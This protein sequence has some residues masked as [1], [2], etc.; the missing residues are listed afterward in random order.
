MAAHLWKRFKDPRPHESIFLCCA[1]E[2]GG[3]CGAT[4]VFGPELL[5]RNYGASFSPWQRHKQ[6]AELPPISALSF[7]FQRT[8]EGLAQVGAPMRHSSVDFLVEDSMRKSGHKSWRNQLPP[9]S[10]LR[11]VISDAYTRILASK[12]VSDTNVETNALYLSLT[13]ALH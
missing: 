6:V 9:L 1:G 12:L 11:L 8:S 4:R 10:R 3:R 13:E 7:L 2:R 5:L